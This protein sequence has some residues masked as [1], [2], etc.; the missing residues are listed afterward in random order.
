MTFY[1]NG[2]TWREG[3]FKDNNEDGV[4]KIYKIDGS[5]EKEETYDYGELIKTKKY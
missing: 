5:L 1:K 3:Q 2:Y 4:I